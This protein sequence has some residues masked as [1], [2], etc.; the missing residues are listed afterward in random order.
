MSSAPKLSLVARSCRRNTVHDPLIES[1]RPRDSARGKGKEREDSFF[2]SNCSPGVAK[3]ASFRLAPS[4]FRSFTG[5]EADCR[6]R[7]GTSVNSSSSKSFHGPFGRI[8]L[9]RA[10]SRNNQLVPAKP[11]RLHDSRIHGSMADSKGRIAAFSVCSVISRLF[12][13]KQIG[14]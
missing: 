8:V 7:R 1:F 6:R 4:F 10:R 13:R 9:A 3:K 14:N 12:H 11:P 5:K 2:S